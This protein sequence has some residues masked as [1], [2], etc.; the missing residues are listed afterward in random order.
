[1]NPENHFYTQTENNFTC[2]SGVLGGV[3]TFVHVLSQK[4][5]APMVTAANGSTSRR[6]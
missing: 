4:F 2:L 5:Y 6:F 3:F 1:M